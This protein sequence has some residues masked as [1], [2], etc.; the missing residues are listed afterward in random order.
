MIYYSL[1]TKFKHNVIHH[2]FFSLNYYNLHYAA[3]YFRLCHNFT[4]QL[5]FVQCAKISILAIF[6]N[7]G[8]WFSFFFLTRFRFKMAHFLKIDKFR[9]N[10]K[11]LAKKK[12]AKSYIIFLLPSAQILFA[13]KMQPRQLIASLFHYNVNEVHSNLDIMNLEIVNF[14]I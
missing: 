4:P 12:L 11:Y 2:S 10:C 6:F 9:M 14:A 8:L 13:K 7:Q 3:E 1:K 5:L